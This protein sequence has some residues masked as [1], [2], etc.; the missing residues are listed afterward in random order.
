MPIRLK[1]VYSQKEKQLS[2][3]WAEYTL[4]NPSGLE[5]QENQ[6]IEGGC[7]LGGVYDQ[8]KEI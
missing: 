6:G 3:F 1:I 4:G 5:F 2:G 7:G 8:I